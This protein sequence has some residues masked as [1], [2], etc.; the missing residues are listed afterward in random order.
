LNLGGLSLRHAP[1]GENS[2][3]VQRHLKSG[4]YRVN[5]EARLM[6]DDKSY[7]ELKRVPP[8]TKVKV[9]DKGN[10]KSLFKAGWFI[11]NEHSWS[12]TPDGQEG[13]IDDSML[14][15]HTLAEKLTETFTGGSKPQLAQLQIIIDSATP[16]E[17]KETAENNAFLAKA[18][19]ALDEDTY[20]GLLPALGVHRAPD[21]SMPRG[22]GAKGHLTGPEA[23]VA[24][25]AHLQSYVADAVKAGRK[26][27]GEVSVVGDADFQAA[28]ERQWV[29]AAGQA[30]KYKGKK[31]TDVCEAFVDVNLPK[32]H[33][34]IH[35]NLGDIGTVI[36]E[37][38]HKYA[39]PTLRDEQIK[40]AAVKGIDHGG[41][42]RLDEGVTEYFT[43]SVVTVQ[44]K[45]PRSTYY[46]GEYLVANALQGKFGE[47]LLAK[48]YFD[49]DFESLKQAVGPDWPEFAERLERFDRLDMKWLK[50]NGYLP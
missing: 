18:R 44:L 29:V 5:T 49:G 4:T 21:R 47:P 43:R 50:D 48:A 8:N 17:V 7:T 36:H 27:E 31:A 15:Y 19:K 28:F 42:S 20:L 11:T 16:Q 25:R 23:D 9:L 33:I 32:R 1:A 3:V 37:G 12:E 10:R 38:M 46:Q 13:W 39:S 41:T 34:W 6:A 2:T 30:A 45:K 24:I 14:D 35:R 26:V 22:P 40:M